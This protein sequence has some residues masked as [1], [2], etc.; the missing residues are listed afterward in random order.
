MRY[1]RL[2]ELSTTVSCVPPMKW[3]KSEEIFSCKCIKLNF[4]MVVEER[5]TD[6][7]CFL[8]IF[9]SVTWL[10][11]LKKHLPF[12]YKWCIT[13]V[14]FI[15]LIF[16]QVVMTNTQSDILRELINPFECTNEDWGW[17]RIFPPPSHAGFTC[18]GVRSKSKIIL[19]FCSVFNTRTCCAY[20][21]KGC[22]CCHP[23][24]PLHN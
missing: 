13:C 3:V 16:S 11:Y 15:L 21:N 19:F 23:S 1:L 6:H 5:V 12:L 7:L 8:L 17:R 20:S 9:W 14:A 22:C 24:P 18:G 10:I 4:W 2:S